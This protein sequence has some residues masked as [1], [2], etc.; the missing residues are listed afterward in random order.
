MKTK[1]FKSTISVLL[2][3]LLCVSVMAPAFSAAEAEVA[4]AA[5]DGDVLEKHAENTTI[6]KSNLQGIF[7]GSTSIVNTAYYG[8]AP[9]PEADTELDTSTITYVSNSAGITAGN[10]LALK[11]TAYTGSFLNRKPNWDDATKRS[12]LT[13]SVRTYY[14]ATFTVSG[15]SDGVLYLNDEAV[16]GNVMG[17]RRKGRYHEQDKCDGKHADGSLS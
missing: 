3:L 17:C 1:L 10:W 2:V 4:A 14:T 5:A 16:S 6:S 9:V 7:G 15:S 11:T 13:F 8:F 12:Q